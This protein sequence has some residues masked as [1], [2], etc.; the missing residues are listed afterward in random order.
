MAF[1]R[2][3]VALIGFCFLFVTIHD[4][5]K[6]WDSG[7][8]VLRAILLIVPGLFALYCIIRLIILIEGSL[9]TGKRVLSKQEKDYNKQVAEGKAWV[10][11][12]QDIHFRGQTTHGSA[13]W[14]LNHH[15]EAFSNI[16]N[17]RG[18][19][20]G[21]GMFNNME[22]N[23]ITVAPPGS[24]KGAALIIPNLL[25]QRD[26]AHSF[27][28]YD[29]K[30]TNAATTARFR[31]ECGHKVIILDPRG[32]QRDYA[33]RHGIR[34]ACYNPL[35]WTGGR[36]LVQFCDKISEYL[37]PDNPANKE[38]KDFE[39]QARSMLSGLLLHYMTWTEFENARH[40]PGFHDYIFSNDLN[41]VLAQ[42]ARNPA[43]D[44]AVQRVA[45]QIMQYKVSERTFGS[46]VFSM[47]NGVTW[48][49][50]PDLRATLKSSDFN[51]KEFAAG[52]HTIYLC[53]P[54]D[55]S[56]DVYGVWGRIVLGQL[57][58]F[59]IKPTDRARADVYYLLDEFPQLGFFPDVVN[60][61]AI[62]REYKIRFWLFVQKIAQLAALYKE[63]GMHDVL[64]A[65]KIQQAIRPNEWPTKEYFSKTL[66][67]YTEVFHSQSQS[68]GSWTGQG[69]GSSVSEQRIA[70]RLLL[71]EE[72]G[73]CE[74]IITILDGYNL[75]LAPMQYW[76]EPRIRHKKDHANLIA[77]RWYDLL[78]PRSDP[79]PNYRG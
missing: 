69:G 71:P 43:L 59:N 13:F 11:P 6:N 46:V 5:T 36:N 51:P 65:C 27:V 16:A 31:A 63:N 26:Y 61:L 17:Y 29:P 56:H 75:Q 64:G 54:F 47:H 44:G 39:V 74:N 8:N 66:G 33:I 55:E 72:V 52:G 18:L 77:K 49:K 37:I 32:L 30:G 2:Y 15:K 20:I 1:T 19:W 28:V 9:S 24:G 12:T 42:M 78:N 60:K 76:R 41:D 21:G 68:D 4:Q 23:L 73:L 53:I 35:E 50:D 48:L 7:L 45:I 3:F 22:G 67:D 40:L 58:E 79:N 38:H 62:A 10:I 70:R 14:M 25:H 57:I 34:P